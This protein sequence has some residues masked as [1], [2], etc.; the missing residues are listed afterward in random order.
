MKMKDVFNTPLEDSYVRSRLSPSWAIGGKSPYVTIAINS[1]DEMVDEVS[2]LSEKSRIAELYETLC[3]NC[4]DLVCVTQCNGDDSSYR[5]EVVGHYMSHP[6]ERVLG[7]TYSEDCAHEA[8]EDAI[9]TTEH[10]Q[11]NYLYAK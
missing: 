6:H 1:H 10:D 3:H 4:W 11:Y 5:W 2:R 9:E 8:I 7:V